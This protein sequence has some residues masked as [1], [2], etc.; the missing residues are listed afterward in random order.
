MPHYINSQA[1]EQ[2]VIF[3]GQFLAPIIGDNVKIW[4]GAKI[5]GHV[6]IEDGCI[7]ACKCCRQ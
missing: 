7:I 5:I 3:K 1:I 4:I 2:N 6:V